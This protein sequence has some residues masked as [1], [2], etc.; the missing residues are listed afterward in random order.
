MTTRLLEGHRPDATVLH[1]HEGTRSRAVAAAGLVGTVETLAARLPRRRYAIQRCERTAS[2]LLSTCAAWCAGQTVVMP[3]TRLDADRDALLARFADAYELVDDATAP[4]PSVAGH[5]SFAVDVAGL[6]DE[7]ATRWPPPAISDDLVAA[8]L[9]TSGSTRVPRPAQKTW[10]SLCRG[11]DALARTLGLAPG[12]YTLAGTVNPQHMFGLEATIMATLRTGCALDAA[13]PRYGADLAE[14][15]RRA[16]QARLPPLWLATTP[17]HLEHFHRSLREPPAIARIVVSTMPMPRELAAQVEADWSARVDEIYG[18]T[19][20]GMIAT[21]RTAAD[22]TFTVAS[23]LELAIAP[24]GAAVVSGGQL[25]APVALDDDLAWEDERNRRFALRG[26]RS[27]MVKVA[28]KRTTLGALGD[29]LR[30]VDGVVDGVFF[31]GALQPGRLCALVVAPTLD[32]AEL[33]RRLAERIDAAFM[34]RPMILVDALPRDDRGKLALTE[35]HRMIS[36]P[37]D[38]GTAAALDARDL[39]CERIARELVVDADHPSLAGHFPGHPVVP[40]VLLLAQVE[41]ALRDRGLRVV[42]CRH[43]KFI[44]PVLPAQT[45]ALDVSLGDLDAV[46]FT[47]R[48]PAGVAV[49]GTLRCAAR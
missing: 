27:D 22:E 28:G 38:A 45:Y 18:S 26:R 36:E 33:R 16:T 12:A 49:I 37:G 3:P 20:C 8:M 43:V 32:E 11:A 23:G 35:L 29:H 14:L 5:V 2:L 6:L 39:R 48:L 21:R 4:T 25:D 30:Q 1:V 44:A 7:G 34:P 42:A 13:R 31:P 41:A 19:E 17:L 15:A 40:A 10:G 24:D 46:K 9:F 47:L